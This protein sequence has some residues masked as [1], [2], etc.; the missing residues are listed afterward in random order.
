MTIDDLSYKHYG[1]IPV[2]VQDDE[3]GEVLMLGY[4]DRTALEKTIETG[5][6]HYYSRSRQEYWLKGGTSGHFQHVRTIRTDICD[7]DT[8]LIRVTQDGAACHEGYRSC[9]SLQLTED[10]QFEVAEK[11][12]F[13]PADVYGRK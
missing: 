12:V 8:L 2:I 9:F 10:G 3:N 4:M 11:R 7:R 13:D 1:L 6:V 5:L